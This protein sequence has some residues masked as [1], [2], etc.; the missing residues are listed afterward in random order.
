M[1]TNSTVLLTGVGAEGQVGEVVAQGFAQ[2]GASLVLVDR[3][4]EHVQARAAVLTA[5][6]H[7]ARGYSCDLSDADAVATLA[8]QIRAEHGDKLRALVHMAGGFGMSGPVAESAPSDW[9]RQLTINLTTAYLTTRAFLPLLRGDRGSL[10]LFSSEAALPGAN[11]AGM[12][13]YAIA[14]QGVAG[15]VRAVAAEEKAH[16]VRANAV[17]PTAIRTNANV[18]S[19]GANVDYVEREEVADVVMFLCSE[20][21]SAITGQ[22]I[23]L[24]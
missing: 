5:S 11:A 12:S 17:A 13:A 9:S 7:R 22:L 6:G 20:R 1:Y 18:A 2:L 15:L 24:S 8:G 4:L 3:A 10:V 21:A 19:M 16:G 14:K 23:A